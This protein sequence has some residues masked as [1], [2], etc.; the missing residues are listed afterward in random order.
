MKSAIDDASAETVY[1]VPVNKVKPFNKHWAF[2]VEAPY[3]FEATLQDLKTKP[4]N[5]PA[6][7]EN[8]SNL[9]DAFGQSHRWR[10]QWIQRRQLGRPTPARQ[11]Q[12]VGLELS[13][14]HLGPRDD[15]DQAQT[16]SQAG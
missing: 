7:A 13:L 9:S 8:I 10:C 4:T 3:M 5:T 16:R 2:E 11:G 6:I 12:R 14:R 1:L 15:Q